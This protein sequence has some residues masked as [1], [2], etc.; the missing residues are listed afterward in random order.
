MLASD[1]ML[2]PL[3]FGCKR[4]LGI[5]GARVMTI[6]YVLVPTYIQATISLWNPHFQFALTP[7]LVYALG[8]YHTTKR[9][10]ALFLLSTF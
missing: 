5:N 9:R 3:F 4:L 2:I 1:I 7:L 10:V 6:L 8:F